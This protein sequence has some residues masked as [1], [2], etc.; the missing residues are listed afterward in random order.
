[1]TRTG[2]TIE[3]LQRF[4][5]TTMLIGSVSIFLSLPTHGL[6]LILS[7]CAFVLVA[8]SMLE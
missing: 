2:P 7:G 1:M 5:L 6:G 4:G 8:E 3:N